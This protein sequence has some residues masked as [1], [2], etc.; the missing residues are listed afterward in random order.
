MKFSGTFKSLD[1]HAKKMPLDVQKEYFQELKNVIRKSGI[2]KEVDNTETRKV[3]I[4][5]QMVIILATK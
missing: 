3:E 4:N 5:C 2:S 1:P